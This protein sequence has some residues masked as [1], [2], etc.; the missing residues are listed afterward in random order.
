MDIIPQVSEEKDG[1]F[2]VP[3][4]PR[5]PQQLDRYANKTM[6]FSEELESDHP[7]FHDE[8]YRKRRT[9]I[10]QKVGFFGGEK[11]KKE[12]RKR[13]RKRKK[14]KKKEKRKG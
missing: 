8:V 13:N 4:F 3:W 14:K 6:E 1:E 2:D 10:V 9:M 12:K 5:H 7:G 11:K